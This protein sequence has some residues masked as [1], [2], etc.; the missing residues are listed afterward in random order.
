MSVGPGSR[1][2]ENGALHVGFATCV[3]HLK[4]E[5]DW[6]GPIFWEGLFIAANDTLAVS[7]LQARLVDLKLPIKVEDGKEG[8]GRHLNTAR[9]YLVMA[10]LPQGVPSRFIALQRLRLVRP[11]LSV[12][13]AMA[14][15]HA[16]FPACRWAW[17]LMCPPQR[18]RRSD[19]QTL[20]GA[21]MSAL[22]PITDMGGVQNDVR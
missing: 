14:A 6:G 17:V 12:A 15:G 10:S 22:P 16:A 1:H 13:W 20:R 5:P 8:D 19:Y 11:F 18:L 4:F 3:G 21:G 2:G 7:L 9:P